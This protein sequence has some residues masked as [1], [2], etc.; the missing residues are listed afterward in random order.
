MNEVINISKVNET[1]IHVNCDMGMADILNDKFTFEVEGAKFHPKVKQRLWDGKIHLFNKRSKLIYRGLLNKVC[2]ACTDFGYEYDVDESIKTYSDDDLNAIEAFLSDLNI[3]S[4]GNP[5]ELRK[6]QLEAVLEALTSI[7]GVF[8]SP[9]ASGKSAIIYSIV[10]YLTK[11]LG[12]KGL[13]IV[14]STTLVEQMRSDFIDYSEINEA[15]DLDSDTHII[16]SGKDKN[17]DKPITIST[18]QSLY[19]LHEDFFAKYDFVIGDECHKFKA[20]Q[21]RG[22]IEKCV[23]AVYRF[24]FTGTLDGSHTN[25]M[26]LEG[27][28]GEVK[29]VTSYEEM[30][31]NH[32]IPDVEIKC[33]VLKHKD[34][35]DYR[36][37]H[38][39]E[40]REK[41]LGPETG[42]EKYFSEID[43]IVE[44]TKR[45][46]FITK[47]AVSQKNNILILVNR[48]DHAKSLYEMIK[49]SPYMSE[50]KTFLMIGSTSTNK[51]ENMRHEMEE[52]DN[53]VLIGTYGVLSTG[54]NIRN[55][56]SVVFAAPSGK[57]RINALQSLGRALRLHK[58]KTKVVLYDIADDLRVG[59]TNTTNFVL[60]HLN[61][62]VKIYSNEHLDY[63][64]LNVEI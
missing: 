47:I 51:R 59:K 21:L 36:K 14:P 35:S 46:K 24:G 33:I 30:M 17:V 40:R 20:N 6:Y 41:N 58:S 25:K 39:K 27:L 43:F 1:F 57:S 26:V 22:I 28:F 48:L 16:Y 13:I 10:M 3:S 29:Q 50:R 15:L 44:N 54:V 64:I 12:L 52:E 2:S 5:I 11:V 60:S 23:N 49:D 19:R 34:Y 4:K 62:R 32:Q 8:I 37:N 7:R 53:A 9:T 55:I 61:E 18:W 31:K 63:Q 38:L 42:T 45:L 56:H